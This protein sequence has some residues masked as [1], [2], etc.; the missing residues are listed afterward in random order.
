MVRSR[1]AAILLTI[2]LTVAA[3]MNSSQ[4]GV[5]V[6]TWWT[7]PD[8]KLALDALA[9][10]FD[11][12]HSDYTF[13]NSVVA[14]GSGVTAR[15]VLSSRIRSGQPPDTFQ[16][17][18]GMELADFAKAG[19]IADI[20]DLYAENGWDRIFPAKLLELITLDGKIYSVPSNVHRANLIWANTEVIRKAGLDPSTPPQGM[21]EWFAALDRIKAAGFVPLAVGKSWTQVHL[22]E[23]VLLAH[24][25]A[26]AYTGLFD[27]RTDWAGPQVQAA[28]QDYATLLSYA[29]PDRDTLEANDQTQL[30]IDGKAAYTVMGDWAEPIFTRQKQLLDV[31]YTVGPVPGTEGI[32]DFLA[33]SFAL[34]VGAKNRDGARA[35][36][37]TVASAE[38]QLALS[39]AK[40]S[41]PARV[42]IDPSGFGPYQRRALDDYTRSEVVPSLAHGTATSVTWLADVTAAVAA[43]SRNND[44]VALRAALIAAATRGAALRPAAGGR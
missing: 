43:F 6:F 17:H 9:Q 27:G 36:L 42:D 44:V 15:D 34:L 37:L 26:A 4:R 33:D 11:E 30:V 32:F 16:A 5:E 3:C 12:Q 38:G 7:T 41:I 22:L 8:D 40:G 19:Q 23:T 1:P 10:V 25:G 31:T 2:M 24:L 29:N 20:R 28:V 35:W 39:R 14:G 18:A 13:V 21:S